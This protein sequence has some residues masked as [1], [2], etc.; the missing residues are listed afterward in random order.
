MFTRVNLPYQTVR[1]TVHFLSNK[2]YLTLHSDALLIELF[3]GCHIFTDSAL[4]VG[5]VIESPCPSVCLSVCLCVPSQNT[6]FRR[7]WRPLV[8]DHIRNFGL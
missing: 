4:L 6:R 8:Q 5:L 3:K 1:L 2:D 7:L